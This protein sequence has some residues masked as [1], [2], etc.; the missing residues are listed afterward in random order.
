MFQLSYLQ[1]AQLRDANNCD[2]LVNLAAVS[3]FLGKDNEV[4]IA[5]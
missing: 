2:A 1:E 3:Q 4:S 5:L